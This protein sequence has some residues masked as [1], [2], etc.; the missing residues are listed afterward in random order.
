MQELHKDS[1]DYNQFFEEEKQRL[2]QEFKDGILYV[3]DWMSFDEEVCR[4]KYAEMG[5][6]SDFESEL[7]RNSFPLQSNNQ[8][9]VDPEYVARL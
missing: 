6:E 8:L 7:S 9:L 4:D 5:V 1:E 2:D 3:K